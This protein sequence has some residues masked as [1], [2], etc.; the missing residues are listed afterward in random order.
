M[1]VTAL[2][3]SVIT[4][5]AGLPESRERDCQLRLELSANGDLAVS[6]RSCSSLHGAACEFSGR[7]RK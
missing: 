7:Y 6:E 3:K 2:R 5:K 4:L 1:A